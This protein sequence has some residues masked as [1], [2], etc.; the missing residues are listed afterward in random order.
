[1][2]W[3]SGGINEAVATS[4]S[5]KAIFV[6]FVEGK[7][8]TSVQLAQAINTADVSSRLEEE[9]FVA[10]RLE[11]GS[12]SYNFFAQIYHVVP[13]PSL[14][15]IGENGMP[16]E[17]VAGSITAA[18]LLKKI[19]QLIAKAGKTNKASSQNFIAAEQEAVVPGTSN[20]STDNKTTDVGSVDTG[21]EIKAA[22]EKCTITKSSEE[23]KTDDNEN[24][25]QNDSV[26]DNKKDDE[27]ATIHNQPPVEE[28]AAKQD[29]PAKELTA[30][31]KLDRAKQLIEEQKKQRVEEE[32]RK[33][34]E[35]ELE[36]R[37]HGRDVQ[38]LKQ[39]QQDLEAKHAHEE[40]MREKAED[41]A[42][43]E[44][45]KKQIEQDK[46]ERR[47]KLMA[48]QELQKQEKAELP[49]PQSPIRP[50]TV[51]TRIQFR[52]PSGTPHMG[53]FDP[54]STLGALRNYVMGNINL[55]FR[56]FSMSISFPRRD[57]THEDDNKTLLEL[58]LVPTAVILILPL[59]KSTVTTSVT[60]A[61]DVGYFS[62]FMWS[63]FARIIGVYNYIVSYFSRGTPK[64]PD[65]PQQDEG[66]ARGS[67]STM[68]QTSPINPQ[69]ITNPGL[70]RRHLAN[71]GGTRVRAEGNIHRLHSGGDDNDENNTWNG[72][73]TQQM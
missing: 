44:K 71:Q 9:T 41:A 57:L 10:V 32:Q 25:E 54:N 37:K 61:Q 20:I 19:D 22:P 8:A 28:H 67:T 56:E 39:K 24:A 4:K 59:K 3:F 52:L 21:S 1:M 38:K 50:D 45:I 11:S 68:G 43:R 47:E 14:F 72:N 17:I 6:V 18:D 63:I 12:E 15:F 34:R 55:P 66:E 31:E 69:N 33:Q 35:R 36:R 60:S 30:D 73:S 5:R 46:L 70:L 13:V 49:K 16:L 26:A 51:V 64:H 65:T 42:V 27:T 53:Q 58:E 29:S 62:G 48:M 40:R 2:K 23:V 7:D